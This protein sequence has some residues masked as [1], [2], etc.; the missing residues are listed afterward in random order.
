[1]AETAVRFVI[2]SL[3]KSAIIA[4]ATVL[5]GDEP[6]DPQGRDGPIAHHLEYGVS[7]QVDALTDDRDIGGPSRAYGDRGR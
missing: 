4:A 6:V 7:S 2:S 3:A 5:T 1:M